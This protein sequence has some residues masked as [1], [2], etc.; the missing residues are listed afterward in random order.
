MDHILIDITIMIVNL[1]L[2]YV[3]K[4]VKGPTFYDCDDCKVTKP[5]IFIHDQNIFVKVWT[6]GNG[7]I[8]ANLRKATLKSLVD[9]LLWYE[10]HSIPELTYSNL[11]RLGDQAVIIMNPNDSKDYLCAL[12]SLNS[13]DTW[14]EIAQFDYRFDPAPVIM[15][16]SDGSKLVMIGMLKVDSLLGLSQELHV[17]QVVPQGI[18]KVYMCLSY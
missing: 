14:A 9:Y 5:F 11:T 7:G 8:H 3:K 18:Y 16:S 1:P 12:T 15:G 10:S 17:L 13:C 4:C 6:K 2:W